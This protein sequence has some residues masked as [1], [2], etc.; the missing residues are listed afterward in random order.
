M[1]E[2]NSIMKAMVDFANT[3]LMNGA[4]KACPYGPGWF[5][6]QNATF[7]EGDGINVQG[8]MQQSLPNGIFRIDINFFN[9]RD[10]NI[11]SFKLYITSWWRANSLNG[12]DRI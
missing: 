9:K 10:D 12:Q 11:L 8:G 6:I 5:R 4:I 2:N 7:R 3:T 1:S